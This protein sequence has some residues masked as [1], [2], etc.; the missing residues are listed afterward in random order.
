MGLKDTGTVN[1]ESDA[2][3]GRG[4]SISRDPGDNG[5]LNPSATKGTRGYNPV[6][7]ELNEPARYNTTS[8]KIGVTPDPVKT[9]SGSVTRVPW[10]PKFFTEGTGDAKVYKCS[11]NLGTVNNV[12]ATNWNA[13]HTLSSDAE[14]VKF[15]VLTVTTSS[16]N[17]TGLT[18]SID[19]SP[20]ITDEVAKDVPPVEFKVLLGAISRASAQMIITTNLQATGD[21]VFRESKAAPAV[22]AEPFH[23]WWRWQ[24]T[25]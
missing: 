8:V 15:V 21:E 10:Q 18:I 5:P 4:R 25:Y 13:T 19:T 24:L 6:K 22:G 1:N 7:F 20:P 2:G 23:R 12:C 9:S 14:T 3:A 16:G 17:V 11:F